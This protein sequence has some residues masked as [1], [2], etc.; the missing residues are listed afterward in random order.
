MSWK[1]CQ[2][3][4]SCVCICM[5]PHPNQGTFNILVFMLSCF[6]LFNQDLIKRHL[7]P[8]PNIKYYLTLIITTSPAVTV[9]CTPDF[10]NGHRAISM[11][12]PI[13]TINPNI[14]LRGPLVPSLDISN[15]LPPPEPPEFSPLVLSAVGDCTADVAAAEVLV[16]SEDE[17]E[18]WVVE[19]APPTP[20]PLFFVEVVVAVVC[21]EIDAAE[22]VEVAEDVDVA[23]DEV[24][25]AT[26]PVF[27][28]V[29]LDMCV[30]ACD[31]EVLNWTPG[32]PVGS[33]A[34]CSEG[35]AVVATV[36]LEVV[37]AP[38]EGHRATSIFPLFIIP[39]S[40]FALTMTLSHAE[41]TTVATAVNSASH[42]SEHP[43]DL[44]SA[45]SQF[46]ICWS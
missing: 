26:V 24:S 32:L 9:H 36:G 8:A 44:K 37:V 5:L 23:D 20:S 2:I 17:V 43:G 25:G 45:T 19:D 27:D 31:A 46:G 39:S 35:G 22:D 16:D 41:L 3:F 18:V 30:V 33:V 6:H 11:T 7:L 38:K 1:I 12:A 13:A 10:H 28:I 15:G 4:Q 14:E 40:V 34:D 42:S 21:E 29:V